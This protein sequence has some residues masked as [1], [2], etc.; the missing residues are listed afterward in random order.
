MHWDGEKKSRMT[1][2]RTMNRN[3]TLKTTHMT[4]LFTEH[5]HTEMEKR[6]RWMTVERTIERK[7]SHA[8]KKYSQ[9][10]FFSK[11]TYA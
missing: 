4:Q 11:C 6:K 1:K 10:S 9:E 8:K 5:L 3:H 7:K 2:E